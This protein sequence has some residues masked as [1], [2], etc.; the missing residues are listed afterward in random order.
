MMWEKIYQRIFW[1]NKS[2]SESTPL[3]AAN[4]N[5]IDNALNIIDDR[6]LYLALNKADADKTG[7]VYIRY[8][9]H[10]D[11]TDFTEFPTESTRYMGVC[12]LNSKEAPRD[13]NMYKWSFCAG[14]EGPKGPKGDKGSDGI[15]P[16]LEETQT[17]E[18]Y[19]ISITDAAGT[20]TISLLN[21]K[22]GKDTGD[23]LASD[24]DSDNS[25]KSAGGIKTY[26]DN[27]IVGAIERS[28]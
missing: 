14:T 27:M 2:T 9:A 28:Y 17:S 20:R 1:K 22:D 24:Y 4:L 12:V 18:G 8:S 13:K 10:A 21:G 15:S 16:I 7:M 23:M 3:A 26:V 5:I 11:G 19:D 6:V 25:V